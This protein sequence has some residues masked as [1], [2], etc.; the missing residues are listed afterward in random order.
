MYGYIYKITN[1]INGKVYIGQTKRSIKIRWKDHIRNAEVGNLHHLYESMRKYGI[2]KFTIEQLDTAETF[3]E[4][5]NKEIYYIQQYDSSNHQKGYNNCK[6]GGGIKDYHHSDEA[7]QKISAASK[8]LIRTPEHCRKISE[9]Q[10]G[11]ANHIQTNAE[12]LKRSLSL[13][14]AYAEGRHNV[15]FTVEVRRKMSEKAKARPHPPTTLGN[16]WMNNGEIQKFIKANEIEI[17]LSNNWVFGQ[18]KHKL[19]ENS[20]N[21]EKTF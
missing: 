1:H 10:K 17:Y 15:N 9:A 6:G 14:K 13:K 19:N 11:I 5:N 20:V 8:A 21:S 12:K 16:K 18:L 7:K 4:L 3:E 2:D